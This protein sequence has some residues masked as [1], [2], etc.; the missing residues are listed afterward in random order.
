[1][2]LNSSKKDLE[3]TETEVILG[4]YR[5][6][7]WGLGWS[8]Q[9]PEALWILFLF[10]CLHQWLRP[11]FE[12][13]PGRYLLIHLLKWSPCSRLW[14]HLLLWLVIGLSVFT[15]TR[16]DI[17]CLGWTILTRSLGVGWG[18]V[19][20][21][22]GFTYLLTWLMAISCLPLAS[23]SE[24]LEFLLFILTAPFLCSLQL[25]R[26]WPANQSDI[27]EGSPSCPFWAA[28]PSLRQ[29]LSASHEF[30]HLRA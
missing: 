29:N 27:K 19:G 18:G 30:S 7:P 25:I 6:C 28:C 22:G 5:V 15:S 4:A 8:R 17:S 20:N 1:M 9:F 11:H 16:I 26:K 21:V 10:I 14:R 2:D 23:D 24:P 12:L 13:V 3:G